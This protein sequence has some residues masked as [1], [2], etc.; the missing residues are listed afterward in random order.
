MQEPKQIQLARIVTRHKTATIAILLNVCQAA[1]S[2]VYLIG[3][4]V[5]QHMLVEGACEEGIDELAVIQSLA[6]DATHELEEVQVVGAPGLVV[7][8]D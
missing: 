1:C 4:W 8:Y 3:E 7:L 6:E 5:S 2:E